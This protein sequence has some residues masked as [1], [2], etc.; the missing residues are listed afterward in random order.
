[1]NTILKTLISQR[2]WRKNT[3]V[4]LT[5]ARNHSHWEKDYYPGPFP[6]TEK[7]RAAA[8]QKY[9]IPVE[10]YK[11][12]PDGSWGD[13]PD[14]PQISGDSK[15]PYYPW[16]MPELK[17]N[18]NEVM[19]EN[20]DNIRE[21]RVDCNLEDNLRVS[22][23]EMSIIF[24][25]TVAIFCGLAEIFENFKMSIPQIPKQYPYKGKTHYTF[26]CDGEN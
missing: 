3:S 13:Y 4:L 2:F 16:D 20:F 7:E 17:R 22:L 12:I 25:C 1:M 5:A 26:E 14:F 8:A 11:P 15:D 9:G 18:F 24:F 19:H 23:Y 10:E 21:D 6:R